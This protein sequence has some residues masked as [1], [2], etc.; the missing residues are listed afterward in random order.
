[1]NHHRFLADNEKQCFNRLYYSRTIT[2]IAHVYGEINYAIS[3]LNRTIRL[4]HQEM[5]DK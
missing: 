5:P 4:G 1:M 3:G 2:M